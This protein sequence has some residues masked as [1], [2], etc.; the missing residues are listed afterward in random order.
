[1]QE[2]KKLVESLKK[3]D[4][5]EL[6]SEQDQFYVDMFKFFANGPAGQKIIMMLTDTN[7]STDFT[8]IRIMK[9][10]SINFNINI[11]A[12]RL[13]EKILAGC[14]TSPI[15]Y[16]EMLMKEVLPLMMGE[17]LE[18]PSELLYRILSI[19]FKYY[20]ANIYNF[21]DKRHLADESRIKLLE[22]LQ[23]I[24]QLLKWE[25]FPYNSAC[26]KDIYWQKLKQI[27]NSTCSQQVFYLTCYLFF[28]SAQDYLESTKVKIDG[29]EIQY[30]LIDG[31]SEIDSPPMMNISHEHPFSPLA[32][33]NFLTAVKSQDQLRHNV[34]FYQ[35]FNKIIMELNITRCINRLVIDYAIYLR[36][37]TDSYNIINSSLM[38]PLE[39]NI[40][41]LS[42]VI[43]TSSSLPEIF[44]YIRLIINDLPSVNGKFLKNLS[45]DRSLLFLPLTK[46]SIV[47][48]VTR[49]L[50]TFLKRKAFKESSLSKLSIDDF[51][52]GSLL[53]LLQLEF[54][55][56]I[57]L[58]E[59]IFDII[60]IKGLSFSLFSAYIINIE[61]IE[62]F[63]SLYRAG[64]V[65][66]KLFSPSLESTPTRRIG[67]RGK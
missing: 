12:P 33:T 20:I 35:D 48:Y 54:Y 40:R 15:E 55:E 29:H 60:R 58:I 49:V 67:T 31:L 23:W 57:P 36:S 42:L 9:K 61:M 2:I 25:P 10:F 37:N 27:E 43:N 4:R 63:Y 45:H 32:I 21:A 16:T 65:K 6:L 13:L 39:K 18:L 14:L 64:E 1:M 11:H 44:E 38:S 28:I 51:Q 5:F 24:G 26:T 66:L 50:I 19:V 30:I 47:Q 34:L 17:I 59:H 8:Y 3:A 52:L 46:N 62:E 7:D 53:V 41:M 56:N 22:F